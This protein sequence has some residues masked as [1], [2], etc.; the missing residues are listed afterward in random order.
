M[1][2]KKK[3]HLEELEKVELSG[4]IALPTRTLW[5]IGILFVI[6][7][8]TMLCYP[9]Y[10]FGPFAFPL[11]KKEEEVEK[12]WMRKSLTQCGESWHIEHI[13]LEDYFDSKGVT[14]YAMKYG[15]TAG[16]SG[17]NCEECECLSGNDLLIYVR[18]EDAIRLSD[19]TQL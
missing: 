6:V 4:P 8:I 19:F 1:L 2:S 14:I 7:G 16:I 15:M 17:V 12:V 5:L 13:P 3:K 10:W 11:Q 9:D 18:K